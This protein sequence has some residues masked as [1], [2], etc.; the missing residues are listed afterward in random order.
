MSPLPPLLTVGFLALRR[1]GG[2]GELVRLGQAAHHVLQPGADAGVVALAGGTWKGGPWGG[3]AD[4]PRQGRRLL[5]RDEVRLRE[6]KVGLGGGVRQ[7]AA[8]L[9]RG[10]DGR[11]GQPSSLTGRGL[12]LIR[13]R[14]LGCWV[15]LVLLRIQRFPQRRHGDGRAAAGGGAG[16]TQGRSGDLR[17]GGGERGLEE[18]AVVPGAWESAL[19][20]DGRGLGVQDAELLVKLLGDLTREL[21][22]VAA[23]EFSVSPVEPAQAGKLTTK[24]T[25]AAQTLGGICVCV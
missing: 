19:S 9:R 5:A 25:L 4:L 24:V 10:V 21:N 22:Q 11:G 8:G 23:V 3:L 7:R 17:G 15:G 6:L 2:I 14:R 12:R 16:Q 1:L 13:G 20:V 18:E